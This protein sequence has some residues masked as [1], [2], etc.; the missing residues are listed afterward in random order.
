M[1]TRQGR[2]LADNLDQYIIPTLQDVPD[3][4]VDV[5]DNT[6]TTDSFPVRGVGELGIEAVAPAICSAIEAATGIRVQRLPVD[7]G[8]LLSALCAQEENFS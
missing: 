5:L 3:Q 4:R 7:P 6:P 8:Y 1:P 2:Y